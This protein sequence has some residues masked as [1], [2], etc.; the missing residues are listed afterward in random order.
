M[1]LESSPYK[2]ITPGIMQGTLWVPSSKSI[3]HRVLIMA[4]LSQKKCS[5][6]NILLSEDINITLEALKKMGY[7]FQISNNTVQFAGKQKIP[8][9][10]VHIYL[11]NSGTS[12]RL[13]TAVA[14]IIPGEFIL[15]GSE[16]MRERPML[17]LI[18]ALT[19]LGSEIDHNRGLLPIRIR[20]KR[21][22]G[23]QVKVEVSKS[24][25]FLTALLLIAPLLRNGL[26][27]N[28]TGNMASRSYVDL[29]LSLLAQVHRSLLGY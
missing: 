16:R 4:A 2:L 17:P 18:E 10:E 27:I 7:I 14:A 15:D 1:I 8:A 28:T 19:Q 24:S 20:G 5:I 11:E 12:A 13:L 23:G 21:L 22:M 25:Q 26:L 6:K 3:S 9:E 29:T